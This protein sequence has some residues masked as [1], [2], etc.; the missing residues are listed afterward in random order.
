[1]QQRQEVTALASQI[2][3]LPVGAKSSA[4]WVAAII[5][6]ALIWYFYE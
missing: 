5:I 2:D 3:S 1:V 6:V 4:G